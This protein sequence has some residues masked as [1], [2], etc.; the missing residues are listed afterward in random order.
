MSVLLLLAIDRAL[1]ISLSASFVSFHLATPPHA[2]IDYHLDKLANRKVLVRCYKPQRTYE[3][4]VK[5]V[6]SGIGCHTLRN[7]AGYRTW[8]RC[9]SL[10]SQ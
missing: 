5:L 6:A 3:I 4:V 9:R 10:L 7:R 8:L 1:Y 2:D